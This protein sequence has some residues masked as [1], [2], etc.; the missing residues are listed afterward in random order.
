[1]TR[2]IL[3]DAIAL[4][5]GD[6]FYT[7]DYTPYNL[8]SWGYQDCAR[9]PNNGAFGAA[10]P[11]LLFRHL[12]RH[13]PANSAYALFPFFIPSETQKNL[14]KLKVAD[15]Y[16]FTRPKPQPLPK[17]LST[18]TG[19]RNVF[20]DST[21]FKVIYGPDMRLLTKGYGFFLVFDDEETHAADK[22]I[23]M[24]ALF[25]DTSALANYTAWYK[26]KTLDLIKEKSITYD[27]VP[28]TYVDIVKDVINLVSV[29]WAAD[30]LC[31]ISL[32]TKNNPSGTFTEQEVNDMFSLLFTCVFE[33]IAPEHGW[34][35]RSGALQA[36]DIINNIIEQSINEAAP[37]NIVGS[38]LGFGEKVIDL[39][40]EKEC[41]AFLRKLAESKRPMKDMVAS[42]I[43]LAVGSSV[44]YSQ[45]E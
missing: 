14:T 4:V 9:D 6:R 45:G 30:K 41:Y 25:P 10:L 40:K 42:V 28:G 7:T 24:H 23:L 5:R 2:A 27:G 21:R 22:A 17:V 8:T 12:P 26:Q 19:I 43:G 1:M 44:N 29:H 3:G 31:G 37:Q 15:Q 34:A 33:N 35:L 39:G 11:K 20:N 16:D 18:L 13:Y 32:K 38:L 36:S